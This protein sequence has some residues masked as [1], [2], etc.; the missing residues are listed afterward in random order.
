[1]P[2]NTNSMEEVFDRHFDD[3]YGYVAYRL[4]PDREA[5]QDVT[6]EVFLAAIECWASYRGEGSLLSWL[7]G[8]ACRKVADRLRLRYQQQRQ[9]DP[10]ELAQLATASYESAS[11]RASFLAQAMATLPSDYV[12]LLEEKYLDRLTV[13][14]MGEKHARTDKAIES[15]L[16]RAREMLRQKLHGLTCE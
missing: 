12:E 4:A 1:M 5:A 14:Q 8:I 15:A 10:I 13:R 16:S 2:H 6:Q 3:V 11:E 9:A 7:R